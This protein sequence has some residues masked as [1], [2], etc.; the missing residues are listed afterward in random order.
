MKAM[1]SNL[2]A[3]GIN[4]QRCRTLT[5]ERLRK[6]I[7]QFFDVSGEKPIHNHVARLI[8]LGYFQISLHGIELTDKAV[9]EFSSIKPRIDVK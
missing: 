9:K 5:I 1:F 3:S 7:K 6:G 4:L 2:E 8:D